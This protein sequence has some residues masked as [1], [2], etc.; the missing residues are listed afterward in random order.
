MVREGK[1]VAILSYGT[2][3]VEALLAA[4]I[5]GQKGVS[6]TVADAR[7]AKPLDEPLIRTLAKN[8]TMLLTLEE[9]SAGG[10]GA[11]VLQFMARDGLLDNG[12]LKVRTLHLPDVFQDH[13]TPQKQYSAA[14]LNAANIAQAIL[15]P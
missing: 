8:H 2:R 1:D 15:K 5:L 13:D 3:L 10:F 9:G 11:F 6:A 14:G 7:F 12:K 4:D